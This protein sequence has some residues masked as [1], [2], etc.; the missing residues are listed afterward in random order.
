MKKDTIKTIL[1]ILALCLIMYLFKQ[2]EYR[3]ALDACKD[4]PIKNYIECIS[5]IKQINK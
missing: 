4:K 5:G 3:N 1:F 2:I